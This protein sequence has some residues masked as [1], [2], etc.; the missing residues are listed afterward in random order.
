MNN[1][2]YALLSGEVD[3]IVGAPGGGSCP[4]SMQGAPVRVRAHGIKPHVTVK[5]GAYWFVPGLRA[6]TAISTLAD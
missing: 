3:P 1:P 5:G 2:G 6:I 4:F